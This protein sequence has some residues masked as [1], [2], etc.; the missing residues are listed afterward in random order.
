[1]LGKTGK[2]HIGRIL[3]IAGLALGL[4]ACSD[5]SDRFG[6]D[7][8][9]VGKYLDGNLCVV[10]AEGCD[11]LLPDGK[12]LPATYSLELP[13]P[14]DSDTL[15]MQLAQKKGEATTDLGTLSI[16]WKGK[17]GMKL[18]LEVTATGRIRADVKYAGGGEH[19]V[20]SEKPAA[21]RD[22]K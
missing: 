2:T 10:A 20:E 22:T 14:G 19:T 4:A 17:P 7:Y 8:S 9:S 3:A 21:M 1:M 5:D 18:A 13:N 6:S 16:P 12:A 15:D 11:E